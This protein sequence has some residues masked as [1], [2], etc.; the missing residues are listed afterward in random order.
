MQERTS[1]EE[2]LDALTRIEQELDDQVML[3]ELGEAEKDQQVIAEAEA[4]LRKPQGRSGAA[5][6]RGAAVGRS[7]Q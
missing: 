7:R 3:I 2:Q 5:R 6:A 4:A 1:L